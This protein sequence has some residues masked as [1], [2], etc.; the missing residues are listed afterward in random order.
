MAIAAAN[1]ELTVS[2]LMGEFCNGESTIDSVAKLTV[3]PVIPS[4]Q[5]T[6][7]S[8]LERLTAEIR[9]EEQ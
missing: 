1:G 3:F 9:E 5:S 2:C 6:L 4:R 7:Y 8:P